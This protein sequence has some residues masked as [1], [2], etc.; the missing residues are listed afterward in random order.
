M[1]K[2]F[3]NPANGYREELS[4]MSS[5]WVILFG[6]LYLIYKGIWTHVLIWFLLL[7]IPAIVTGGPG[8]IISA[9]LVTIVYACCIQGIIE[10]KY[11]RSGWRKVSAEQPTAEQPP[12]QRPP[13]ANLFMRK[14]PSCAEDIQIEAIKCRYCNTELT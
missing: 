13:E 10:K 11:L 5:L 6:A 14:C 2:I 4:G 12:L 9:P 7:L 3:E 1:I 8:L